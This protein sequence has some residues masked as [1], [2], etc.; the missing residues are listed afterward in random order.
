MSFRL[1]A[2]AAIAAIVTVPGPASAQ[3]L[4]EKNISIKP[5]QTRSVT[6]RMVYAKEVPK[7]YVATETYEPKRNP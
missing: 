7:A 2:A 5:N 6:L 1:V 3:V 4:T